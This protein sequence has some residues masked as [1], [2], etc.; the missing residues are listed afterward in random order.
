[1]DLH[2][3]LPVLKVTIS[4]RLVKYPVFKRPLGIMSTQQDRSQLPLAL[5]VIGAIRLASPNASK[6]VQDFTQIALHQFPRLPVLRVHTT[7]LPVLMIQHLALK[8][9]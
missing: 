5:Q 4:P 6:L 1:M 9:T 7:P 2:P 8:P 3:R